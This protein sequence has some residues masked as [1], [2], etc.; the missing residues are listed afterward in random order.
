MP[1]G[2][3]R[4]MS[5]LTETASASAELESEP[6]GCVPAAGLASA[7]MGEEPLARADAGVS[8]FGSVVEASL[9]AGVVTVL[10]SG[11][12]SVVELMPFVCDTSPAARKHDLATAVVVH[13]RR[14]GLSP[15]VQKQKGGRTASP[16]AASSSFP[17]R[18]C[19]ACP[20]VRLPPGDSA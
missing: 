6:A 1:P 17:L 18:S 10:D 5:C 4:W 2:L 16:R 9:P 15:H 13:W 7:G 8:T 14:S 19:L 20:W 12:V 11:S 3:C